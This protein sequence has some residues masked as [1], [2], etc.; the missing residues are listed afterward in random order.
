MKEIYLVNYS[1]NGIKTIDKTV[2]LS[3]YKKTFQKDFDTQEYNIKGIYGMNG[4][5]KTGIIASVDILKKLLITPDY[6]NNLIIQT[7]LD[8]IINKKTQQLSI[9]ADFVVNVKAPLPLFRYNVVLSRDYTGKYVISKEHLSFKNANTRTDKF[10]VL[11]QVTEGVLTNF[12]DK[13]DSEFVDF[14]KEKTMNLLSSNSV[15]A[16]FLE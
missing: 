15:R 14:F 8:E 13:A 12:F 1:V 11:F 6:L 3:F 10:N 2:S 5:G 16:L 7:E 9:E 4:S